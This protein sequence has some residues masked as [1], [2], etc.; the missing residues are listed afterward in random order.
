MILRYDDSGDINDGFLH[1]M[2][3][4]SGTWSVSNTKRGSEAWRILS[5]KF[6]FLHK[7]ERRR[8]RIRLVLECI[9]SFHQ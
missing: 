6:N 8:E 4:D 1:T 9:P 5:P 7:G 3:D 2:W